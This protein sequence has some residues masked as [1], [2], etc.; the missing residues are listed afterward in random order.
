MKPKVVWI[1]CYRRLCPM[2][3]LLRWL[4]LPVLALLGLAASA[5]DVHAQAVYVSVSPRVSYYSAPAP[6][7]VATPSYVV[8]T[9]SYVV[10]T[11]SYVVATPAPV[12]VATPRFTLV[13]RRTVVV[14][15]PAPVVTA[16]PAVVTYTESVVVPGRYRVRVRY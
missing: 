12:V 8:A 14:A 16:S 7:V 3:Y 10:A 5:G 15:S 2:K 9:P 6:V 13:P 1:M 4:S 11:P